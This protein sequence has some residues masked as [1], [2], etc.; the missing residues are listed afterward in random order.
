MA[1]E[2]L[3][4][5]D[6]RIGQRG[7]GVSVDWEDRMS[8]GVASID[9]HH[10]QVWRR[11][12][13]L[14]DAV[15][16]GRTAEV[17]AALR[18]LHGYLA[19]QNAEEERWMADAGY[20]GAGEHGRAHAEIVERI[21]V[22]RAT[23]DA[24]SPKSLL[25]AAEWVARALEAHMRVED[26]KLGRFWTA[27]ENLRRLAENGPGVGASLTPIPGSL[28]AVSPPARARRTERDEKDGGGVD[29]TRSR[30]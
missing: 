15:G 28:A 2:T 7:S 26:L 13:H 30:G 18:F 4:P 8:V 14:A 6:T 21:R 12:R 17:S 23:A 16:D 10:R 1:R 11:V 29:P 24:A 27:R 9:V 3:P 22:A 25:E 5:H 20:P 19:E